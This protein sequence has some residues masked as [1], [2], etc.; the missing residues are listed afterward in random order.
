VLKN[1]WF[2]P[3]ISGAAM[4]YDAQ[5]LRTLAVCG[6]IFLATQCAILL[7]VRRYRARDTSLPAGLPNPRLERIW[8]IATAALFLGLLALSGGAWARVQF[9]S[10]PPNSEQIEVLAKQFAWS[11]R[12]PGADGRFGRTSTQLVNDGAGN[13]FGIDDRDPAGK[14]DIVS[15]TLRV[16]VGRPVTLMLTSLDVIHSFFLRELRMKQDVVPGMRIPLSFKPE[17]VGAYEIP[18]AELCGL[19][20]YQMRTMMIVM[21]ADQYDIWKREQGH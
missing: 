6:A 20:H 5:F 19:G 11:F 18:C 17:R 13:A 12:Y 15:G 4:A 16:P 7:I 2:P 8:T 9:A 21:P 3:A 1:W 14:D 10:P